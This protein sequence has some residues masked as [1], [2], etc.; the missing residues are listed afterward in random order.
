MIRSFESGL[1]A[2]RY[3]HGSAHKRI[4]DA[5]ARVSVPAYRCACAAAC[6]LEKPWPWD[7][8]AKTTCIIWEAHQTGEAATGDATSGEVAP[9]IVGDEAGEEGV[10]DNAIDSA[11]REWHL[12]SAQVAVAATSGLSSATAWGKANPSTM[13]FLASSLI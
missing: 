3:I 5:E 2:D 8:C 1:L 6:I 7:V 11:R 12:G 13:F 9:D 4:H 10:D